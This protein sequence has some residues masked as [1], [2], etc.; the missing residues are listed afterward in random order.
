MTGRLIIAISKIT[1]S[2]GRKWDSDHY[3]YLFT[4]LCLMNIVEVLSPI[5]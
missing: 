4:R 3:K 1:G 2:H 5:K